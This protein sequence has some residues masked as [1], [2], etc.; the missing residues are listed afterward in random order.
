MFSISVEVQYSLQ[1]P[2]WSQADFSIT[3]R[4]NLINGS[5]I[6]FSVAIVTAVASPWQGCCSPVHL[7]PGQY[8]TLKDEPLSDISTA[9]SGVTYKEQDQD[10][11]IHH[12]KIHKNSMVIGEL[13]L[14][15]NVLCVF[16]FH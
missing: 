14:T 9:G 2:G 7:S 4:A 10:C 12:E 13:F 6:S 16:Y 8:G 11:D 15:T 5:L 1:H 3:V